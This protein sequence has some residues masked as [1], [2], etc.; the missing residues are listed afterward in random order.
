MPRVLADFFS[1]ATRVCAI[2]ILGSL[3]VVASATAQ[4]Q[5]PA[6]GQQPTRGGTLRIG[7][8][9][10]PPTLNPY[11]NSTAANGTP[12]VFAELTLDGLT[13]GAP[14]G[15][16]L[17]VLAAEIPTQANGDVSPD[18]TIV[19]W[20]LKPGVTWSDGESFTSQDVVFT[21]E[22]I[23][24]P[25]NPVLN[26]GDYA[27]IDSVVAPDDDTVVVTYKQLYA[28]YR[29]AFPWILPSHVFRGQ[30]SMPRN[31]STRRSRWA[32]GRLWARGGYP[33]TA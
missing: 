31:R 22:M 15:S 16:Y 28:P 1:R 17:P 6:G 19:T 9:S 10:E 7:D 23:M 25:A 21:Y 11:F 32:R 30:T 13:R 29:Q 20:K 33:G 18:G 24:D 2:A 14:D 3:I 27:V 26:R 12:S 5:V 4:V 8:P